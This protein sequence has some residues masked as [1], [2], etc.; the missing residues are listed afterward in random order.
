MN[1]VGQVSTPELL[2][3]L[4]ANTVAPF[5]LCGRLRRVL[6]PS[7]SPSAEAD[8]RWG[9]IVNVSALEGKFSVGKK[10][11]GHPHTNMAKAALNMLTCTSAGALAQDRILM[12]CVDTVRPPR[13]TA[14][15]AAAH[16]GCSA[17]HA[18]CSMQHGSV[19]VKTDEVLLRGANS[20]MLK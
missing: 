15:C 1:R 2:H 16:V 20:P 12:N 18:A 13:C 7:A 9:H 17:H 19:C 10:G 8:G 11:A 6:S 4:S 5:V 14:Q 3:T